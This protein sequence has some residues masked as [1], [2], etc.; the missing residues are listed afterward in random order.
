MGR[1]STK[2][3]LTWVLLKGGI[4]CQPKSFRWSSATNIAKFDPGG[5]TKVKHCFSCN[6]TSIAT[7]KA[8][9][10][11]THCVVQIAEKSTPNGLD[12]DFRSAFQ[13]NRKTWSFYIF[14]LKN[15]QQEHGQL[16]PWEFWWA[17]EDCDEYMIQYRCATSNFEKKKRKSGESIFKLISGP[18]MRKCHGVFAK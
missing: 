6:S 9:A 13:K 16:Q 11:K 14:L 2:T 7:A 12:V 1:N 17:Q 4:F 15:S 10:K 8:L 3:K 5:R 18:S